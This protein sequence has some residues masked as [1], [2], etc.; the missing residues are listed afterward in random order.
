LEVKRGTAS[1]KSGDGKDGTKEKS[2][3]D[4]LEREGYDAAR[5]RIAAEILASFVVLDHAIVREVTDTCR[6]S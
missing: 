6:A 5:R 4:S 3:G 2:E 1:G